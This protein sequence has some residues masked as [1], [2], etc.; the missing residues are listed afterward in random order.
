MKKLL[1]ISNMFLLLVILGGCSK[2]EKGDTGTPG[3]NG[4]NGSANVTAYAYTATPSNWTWNSSNYYWVA[5]ASN[6]AITSSVVSSGNVSLFVSWDNTYWSACPYEY[7]DGTTNE[8]Y[9]YYYNVGNIFFTIGAT[10]GSALTLPSEV[11]YK[12]VVIPSSA[13]MTGSNNINWHDWSQVAPL[14]TKTVELH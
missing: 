14:I 2:G 1:I 3:A 5:T 11:Y 12:L 6:S 7:F 9:S 10:N 4:T 8:M 13:R